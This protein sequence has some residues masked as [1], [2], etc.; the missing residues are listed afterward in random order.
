MKG[1]ECRDMLGEMV[2]VGDLVV[3]IRPIK[4]KLYPSIH[5]VTAIPASEFKVYLEGKTYPF[6]S[7]R[8]LKYGAL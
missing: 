6:E 4:G 7:S 5:K 3:L 1:T 2:H 8:F